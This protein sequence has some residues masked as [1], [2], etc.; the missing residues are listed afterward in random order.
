V[1]YVLAV[2]LRSGTNTIVFSPKS[3]RLPHPSSNSSQCAITNNGAPHPEPPL[4][5]QHA[6]AQND[7]VEDYALPSNHGNI[8]SLLFVTQLAAGTN[9][10]AVVRTS[11][12]AI[13]S[14]ACSGNSTSKPPAVLV[15]FSGLCVLSASK[16]APV[17]PRGI[18][19]RWNEGAGHS[20]KWM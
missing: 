9:G 1:P 13:G 19:S 7:M 16:Y 11:T 10:Y 6:D 15:T 14:G 20:N 8:C 17:A 4:M 2:R 18:L 5:F 12:V 3:D